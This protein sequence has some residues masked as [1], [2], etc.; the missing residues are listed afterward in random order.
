[1]ASIDATRMVTK[2]VA[3]CPLCSEDIN[4]EV[5]V[6]IREKQEFLPTDTAAAV[7]AF[8]GVSKS[9]LTKEVALTADVVSIRVHHDCRDKNQ[10]GNAAQATYIR[11]VDSTDIPLNQRVKG[12]EPVECNGPYPSQGS[13][14]V[15]NV[16]HEH[17]IS[18]SGDNW[19]FQA[20]KG[21]SDLHIAGH[22]VAE[23][24]SEETLSDQVN[25]QPDTPTGWA[26]GIHD[27]FLCLE[28][29]PHWHWTRVDGADYVFPVGTMPPELSPD[30]SGEPWQ[31]MRARGPQ[32]EGPAI[33]GAKGA[34][35][36]GSHVI[37]T[38]TPHPEGGAHSWEK[39]TR[40]IKDQPQA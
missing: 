9:V 26:P 15:E 30:W 27:S 28:K 2:K 39:A 33:C 37:C 31:G 36:S 16:Q 6:Q 23:T 13:R 29:G 24:G 34:A 14:C 5:Q 35:I 19:V 40:A 12:W 21:P 11:A 18:P 10:E 22:V 4:A 38:F 32:T 17:W 20:G 8:F 25:E 7:G 1:M 3:R